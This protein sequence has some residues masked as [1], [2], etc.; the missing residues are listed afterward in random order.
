M[1]RP[2]GKSRKR[3]EDEGQELFFAQLVLHFSSFASLI[4]G[5]QKLDAACAPPEAPPLIPPLHSITKAPDPHPKILSRRQCCL[6]E[7]LS[8][9]ASRQLYQRL[10]SSCT[11]SG[12]P[13]S[14][15]SS[16]PPSPPLV[17][18]RVPVLHGVLSTKL[19]PYIPDAGGLSD[20]PAR[21]QQLH[22]RPSSP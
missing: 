4:V 7:H 10:S 12:S 19:T 9:S 17:Q 18:L 2:P 13:S 22:Q 16:A 11:T 21:H 8:L 20:F 6:N 14:P 1:D 5:Q 15:C 3:R